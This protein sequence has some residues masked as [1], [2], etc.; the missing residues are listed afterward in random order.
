MED[1]TCEQ[2]PR[3]MVASTL[4]AQLAVYALGTFIVLRF[5]L[6]FAVIYLACILALEYRLVRY[7][8]VD[9]YY[10]GKTCCF[11]RGRL[12][13]LLF[14][15]GDPACFTARQVGWKDILPDFLVALVPL[16]LGIIIL[17]QGF[18]LLI[19]AAMVALS[20]LAFPGSGFIRSRWAC[21][22]C[23][24]REEGCPAE[25]LFSRKKGKEAG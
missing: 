10:Y 17:V 15:K 20:I 4:L 1:G 5:G 18:D 16:V 25:G 14:G 12:C 3:W 23:R 21:R 13:A 9:C 22:F 24:Q 11:G 19:L 7:H 2:Y 8:C 6:A